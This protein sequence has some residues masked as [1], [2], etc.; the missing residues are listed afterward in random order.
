[1][2]DRNSCSKEGKLK[3]KNQRSQW[4]ER[5]FV[6]TDRELRYY[7]NAKKDK[8]PKGVIRLA[9]ILQA[10]LPR[11]ATPRLVAP[12]RARA[13]RRPR[14]SK[15]RRSRTASRSAAA[16]AT[17]CWPPPRPRTPAPGARASRR[18]AWPQARARRRS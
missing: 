5:H 17:F 3:K 14:G 12:L 4:Q 11:R 13:R 8:E 2:A 7:E 18:D 1:M 10:R 15:T 9:G 16:T 6:Q